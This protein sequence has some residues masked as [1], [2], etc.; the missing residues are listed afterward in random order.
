MHSALAAEFTSGCVLNSFP[1]EA[2]RF[3]RCVAKTVRINSDKQVSR[4]TGYLLAGFAKAKCAHGYFPGDFESQRTAVTA[5]SKS[6]CNLRCSV[7]NAI[8]K[9]PRKTCVA[10]ARSGERSERI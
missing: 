3:A 7:P 8:H 6:H 2:T 4:T 1:F 9:P 5:A 10:L